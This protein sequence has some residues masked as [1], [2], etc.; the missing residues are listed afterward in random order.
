MQ[1]DPTTTRADIDPL[2]G[3]RLLSELDRLDPEAVS[4]MPIRWEAGDPPLATQEPC[5]VAVTSG[6]I[7]LLCP[8]TGILVGMAGPGEMVGVEQAYGFPFPLAAGVVSGA[9]RGVNLNR[10][11]DVLE[12]EVIS[13]G[14]TAALL[15][16]QSFLER[17]VTCNARHSATGR[18]SKLFLRLAAAGGD[19]RL[20]LTQQRLSELLGIQRTSVNAAV[21]FLQARAAVRVR[22]GKIELLN[23]DILRELSC[24]CETAD[25]V[26][27]PSQEPSVR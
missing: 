20:L 8:E 5:V 22:R 18:L 21:A 7:A 24:G 13:A 15:R 26:G 12:S 11:A 6:V 27:F 23:L 25:N 3:A 2:P 17:E 19:N 16:R 14:T 1:T 9:G 10:C 4:S